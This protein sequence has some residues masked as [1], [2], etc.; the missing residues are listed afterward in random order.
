[1]KKE[2]EKNEVYIDFL[3][4]KKNFKEERKGFKTYELAVKWG[5]KNLE[6]FIHDMIHLYR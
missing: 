3:N 4:K 2:K 5:K 6:N 1:M